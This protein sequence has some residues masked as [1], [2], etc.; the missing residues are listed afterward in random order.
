[1]AES[2]AATNKR[3]DDFMD[4]VRSQLEII[5]AQ[6]IKMEELACENTELRKQ[7]QQRIPQQQQQNQSRPQSAARNNRSIS[8]GRP[9]GPTESFATG[10]VYRQKSQSRNLNR[11]QT[12][13]QKFNSAPSYKEIAAMSI[14]QD[15]RMQPRKGPQIVRAESISL[16]CVS[17]RFLKKEAK[18]NGPMKATRAI[19]RESFE[20]PYIE[21]ISPLGR[22]F[23]I[24]EIFFDSRHEDKIR[25]K[26]EA[27]GILLGDFNPL[28]APPHQPKANIDTMRKP[29]AGCNETMKNRIR[30]LAAPKA[31]NSSAPTATDVDMDQ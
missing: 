26:L 16:C 11:N 9:S 24:A 5:K 17:L 23:S 2:R 30:A 1:M 4:T 25:T 10:P 22:G 8:R 7:L 28:A 21:D 14:C 3:I 13:V 12:F 6:T 18:L 27:K 29:L 15:F 19:F 31:A 20:L